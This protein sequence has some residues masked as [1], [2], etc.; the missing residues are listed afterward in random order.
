[1]NPS[2][3]TNPSPFNSSTEYL[4][5]WFNTCIGVT[6]LG[7]AAQTLVLNVIVIAYYKNIVKKMVP[8]M[9]IL[10]SATD[11]ITGVAALLNGLMF[12]ILEY[13]PDPKGK[14][15]P[16]NYLL[17]P[18]Y[19]IFSITFRVSAFLNLIISIVRTFNITRPFYRMRRVTIGVAVTLYTAASAFLAVALLIKTK[20][21]LLRPDREELRLLLYK[22]SGYQILGYYG[23]SASKEFRNAAL[24]IIVPFVL[25]SVVAVIC[26]AIQIRAV[27][28]PNPSRSSESDKNKEI[29]KTILM[30]TLLFFFCNTVYIVYPI[31]YYDRFVLNP[32]KERQTSLGLGNIEQLRLQYCLGVLC[33]YINAAFNPAILIWRGKEIRGS[34]RNKVTKVVMRPFRGSVLSLVASPSTARQT[35]YTVSQL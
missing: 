13:H 2:S 9:Y 31:I 29:T 33:P 28:K 17:V 15:N 4:G 10:L 8:F 14:I 18:T 26:M 6:E 3:A 25:P 24:F 1:M 19:F 21:E 30:L 27:L 11:S 32:D 23:I 5:K 34:V 12:L 7:L 35:R 22:P 20:V 16:G